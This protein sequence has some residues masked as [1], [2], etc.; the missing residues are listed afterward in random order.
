[1]RKNPVPVPV[2]ASSKCYLVVAYERRPTGTP[3][4]RANCFCT[5]VKLFFGVLASFVFSFCESSIET[6]SRCLKTNLMRNK[7]ATKETDAA[8]VDTV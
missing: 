8:L 2:P 5:C 7:G 1:M 3:H 6:N 4:A